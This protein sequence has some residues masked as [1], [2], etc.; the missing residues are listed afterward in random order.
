MSNSGSGKTKIKIKKGFEKRKKNYFQI[1]TKDT[2]TKILADS[3][4]FKKAAPKLLNAICKAL[5][6]ECGLIWK[7][8][9]D[10]KFLEFV[11]SWNQNSNDFKAFLTL[12]REMTFPEGKGLPGRVWS[13]GK[14]LWIPDVVKDSNFPRAPIAK[15]VNLHGAFAY[16]ILLNK[17][18]LGIME[19]FSSKVEQPDETLLDLMASVGSQIGQQIARENAELKMKGLFNEIKRQKQIIDTQK[20]LL[21]SKSNEFGTHKNHRFSKCTFA[22]VT[23]RELEI[24]E[25]LID[26]LSSK[27][28]GGR[29]HLS[30]HTVNAHRRNILEK[31]TCKTTAELISF[32]LQSKR[33]VLDH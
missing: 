10:K 32:A 19:F 25:Y 29:L 9:E 27:Q 23:K 28:I 18:V 1:N 30:I 20:Q 4:Y 12:S 33:H 5:D 2:A 26:G 7:V 3:A 13:S 22:G 14:P 24:I 11:E 17:K 31:T 15:K 16:P 6:W 21:N 8:N